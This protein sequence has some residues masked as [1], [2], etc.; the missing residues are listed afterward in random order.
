V[1]GNKFVYDSVWLVSM[2]SSVV[3]VIFDGALQL[4]VEVTGICKNIQEGK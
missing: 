1:V 2:I 4:F 3:V